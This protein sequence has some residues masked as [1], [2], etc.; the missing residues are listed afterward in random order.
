LI[1]KLPGLRPGF[2][3]RRKYIGEG[4]QA[5]SF[6][7]LD[8]DRARV[9]GSLH[10]TTVSALL[11]MG[12]E[13]IKGGRAAVIDLAGVTASDSSGLALLIEWLSEAKAATRALRYENIPS[14]LQQL[15]RLSEVE[16]L[17]VPG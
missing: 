10:F 16:E 4:E 5:A 1:A 14:Q 7:V 15:A 17:L 2:L 9:I 6:E 3:A 8:G 13:A 12:V 11:P